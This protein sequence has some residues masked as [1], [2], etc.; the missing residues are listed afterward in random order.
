M[1]QYHNFVGIDIGKDSFYVAFYGDP[2]V[3]VYLNTAEGRQKFYQDHLVKSHVRV[4]FF[5]PGINA[6]FDT[7][8]INSLF[9]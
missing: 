8:G 7:V 1:T 3:S 4:D 9:S 5:S 6:P 2:A